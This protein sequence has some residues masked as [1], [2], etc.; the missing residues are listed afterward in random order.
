MQ[1]DRRAIAFNGT[2]C[3]PNCIHEATA[4]ALPASLIDEVAVFSA[5]TQVP[6]GKDSRKLIR[7]LQSCGRRMALRV[8]TNA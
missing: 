6:L 7:R 5:G 1:T 4:A 2:I 3:V 8:L